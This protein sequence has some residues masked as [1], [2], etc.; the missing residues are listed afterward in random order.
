MLMR[1]LLD[2]YT[3]GELAQGGGGAAAGRQLSA[4]ERSK[5]MLTL[6]YLTRITEF[7]GHPKA[8]ETHNAYQ[9]LAKIHRMFPE[10]VERVIRYPSVGAWALKT[11]RKL[12]KGESNSAAPERMNVI[13]A[14]AA[15]HARIPYRTTTPV[16]GCEV[17]IPS[18]G[19]ALFDESVNG[20]DAVIQIT[21]SG[22][23][24]IA[25]KVRVSIPLNPLSSR[26]N[27][28]AIRP[29]RASADGTE[30]QLL[31]DDVDP[32]RFEGALSLATRLADSEV[33]HWNAMFQEAWHLLV[34]GHR[35]VADEVRTM[36]ISLTPL[37]THDPVY[38]S[39]ATSPDTF[40]SVA[41]TQ[42]AGG[43]TLAATLA[44]EMQH[45]KLAAVLDLAELVRPGANTVY[46][47]PWRDDPR[48]ALALLHGAY[49]HLGVAGFWRLQRQAPGAG[50]SSHKEYARWRQA[51]G[52]T[53]EVLL[54]SSDITDLGRRFVQGMQNTLKTWQ[55]D[56]VP[57]AAAELA[58]A[59]AETHR[60]RWNYMHGHQGR[61]K[62]Q[63]SR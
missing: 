40:G 24:V 62:S 20:L 28:Q 5:H 52:E 57:T 9:A 6:C 15:I 36:L 53:I 44:H 2:S 25:S 47:A 35:R 17:V 56:R 38:G 58:S 34:H 27:W 13:A 21:G 8:A 7:L 14:A 26:E 55:S 45:S 54:A 37:E 12:N 4:V 61:S 11:V 39:S 29:L 50:L 30:I 32:H 59:A 42:P 43:V 60:M 48:P 33:Q 18:L 49:A 31:L 63:S 16:V 3:L 19:R 23:E 46:Y 22:A 10:A 1:H 51:V 41:L